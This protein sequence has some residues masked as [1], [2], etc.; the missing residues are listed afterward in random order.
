MKDVRDLE[1]YLCGLIDQSVPKNRQFLDQ[2]LQ[3]WSAENMSNGLP[4]NVQVSFKVQIK[5]VCVCVIIY[6]VHIM[7]IS[8]I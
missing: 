8:S 7:F 6:H 4:N 1:E 2:V 3:K 5:C